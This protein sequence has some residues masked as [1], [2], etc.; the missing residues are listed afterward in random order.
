MRH[1]SSEAVE[2]VMRLFAAM[3]IADQSEFEYL[4][5]KE[6]SHPSPTVMQR[7]KRYLRPIKRMFNA[8]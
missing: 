8:D 7:A 1:V 5:C 3:F 4:N 2:K 6:S